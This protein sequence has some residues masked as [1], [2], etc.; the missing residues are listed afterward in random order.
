MPVS[1][2]TIAFD[3]VLLYAIAHCVRGFWQGNY[4]RALNYF[5]LA[6]ILVAAVAGSFAYLVFDARAV[7]HGASELLAMNVTPPEPVGPNIIL[8]D[9]IFPPFGEGVIG[10]SMLGVL[11]I[12]EILVAVGI[13]DAL[14]RRRTVAA[15]GEGIK[16]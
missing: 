11:V 3:F 9:C 8:I 14:N 10:Y 12:F 2:A 1:L 4:R 15:A 6:L 16:A 13:A 5:L 7:E